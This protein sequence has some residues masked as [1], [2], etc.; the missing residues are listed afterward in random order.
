M[1]EGKQLIKRKT[2]EKAWQLENWK[3]DSAAK[4][5]N[6][7]KGLY[8][9]F[10]DDAIPDQVKRWNVQTFKIK[11]GS[12]NRDSIAASAMWNEIDK[13]MDAKFEPM[14]RALIENLRAKEAA[15]KHARLAALKVE[16]EMEHDSD[17][18]DNV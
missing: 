11:R 1:G 8:L 10:D 12:R 14:V 18:G 3:W 6:R 2:N 4:I 15:E 17:D 7:V 9:Y 5:F 16:D 13:H